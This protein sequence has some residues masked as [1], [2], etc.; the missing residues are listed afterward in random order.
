M[1]FIGTKIKIS[2]I[3]FGSNAINMSDRLSILHVSVTADLAWNKHIS[4]VGKSAAGS[5]IFHAHASSHP[6]QSPN[7]PLSQIRFAPVERGQQAF[8]CHPG[9]N[10]ETSYPTKDY[11]PLPPPSPRFLIEQAFPY[12]IDT[13]TAGALMSSSE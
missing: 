5:G 6:L 3:L 10:F 8:S 11:P 7:P 9:C 12:F 2:D 13:I 1:F 4:Y